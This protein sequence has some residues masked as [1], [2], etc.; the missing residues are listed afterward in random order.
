M[1]PKI[2]SAY[3]VYSKAG[4]KQHDSNEEKE[5]TQKETTFENDSDDTILEGVSKLNKIIFYNDT[6]S[7][8]WKFVV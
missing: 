8:S 4:K 7:G 2:Y 1:C 6:D 5:K 3:L